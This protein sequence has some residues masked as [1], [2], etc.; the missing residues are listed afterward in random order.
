MRGRQIEIK[1]QSNQAT[2]KKPRNKTEA[3]KTQSFD[4]N[5]AGEKSR[6]ECYHHPVVCH[7]RG[8]D[9]RRAPQ[10]RFVTV[11]A[12]FQQTTDRI[13]K[14]QEIKDFSR[15]I[16]RIFPKCELERANCDREYRR[17][18]RRGRGKQGESA[19]LAFALEVSAVMWQ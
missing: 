2:K 15:E 6:G 11:D 4:P 14:E 8:I 18:P 12:I 13:R 10:P 16:G 7:A 3:E 9:E 5:Y 19:L 17:N 1:E